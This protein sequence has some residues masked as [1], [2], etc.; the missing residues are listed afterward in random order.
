[1]GVSPELGDVGGDVDQRDVEGVA[2]VG[3]G[4]HLVALGLVRQVLDLPNCADKVV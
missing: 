2:A 3:V 1:M 4:D